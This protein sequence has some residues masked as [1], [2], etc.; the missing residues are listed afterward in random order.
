MDGIFKPVKLNYNGNV[1]TVESHRV[2]GL[3]EA[4][5][6][7]IVMFDLINPQCLRN[8]QLAK[9]YHSALVYAGADCILE[10]VYDSLFD[11]SKDSAIEKINGLLS[12]MIPP[13]RLQKN[14]I[15]K[16][17]KRISKGFAWCA[18]LILGVSVAAGASIM[19]FGI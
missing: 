4:I 2:M 17:A 16:K 18:L 8:V 19:N 3:I 15:K 1:F 6:D 11:G 9:A 12:M 14:N 5:E 7:H 13:A 10:E